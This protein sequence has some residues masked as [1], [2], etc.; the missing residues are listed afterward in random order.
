M[1]AVGKLA[2]FR[3]QDP[4]FRIIEEGVAGLAD[5]E[6]CFDL[7]TEDVVFESARTFTHPKR[8]CARERVSG[9]AEATWFPE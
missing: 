9:A 3:A 6:H 5:S 8:T 4:F 2:D 1:T 7:L